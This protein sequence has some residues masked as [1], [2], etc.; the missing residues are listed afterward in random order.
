MLV[1]VA[2]TLVVAAVPVYDLPRLMKRSLTL[3][4]Y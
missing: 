3:L 4:L 2:E 1:S